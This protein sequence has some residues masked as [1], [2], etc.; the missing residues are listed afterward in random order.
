MLNLCELLLGVA[1][2]AT[3]LFD[4]F[5]S[6]VVPRWTPR[7]AFFRIPPLVVKSVWPVW[8]QLGQRLYPLKRREYFL[9]IFAPLALMLELL[10]WVLSLIFGYGLMLYAL[11]S[12]IQPVM[13]DFG[14]ALY[15]AGT[16]VF[17]LGFGDLVATG[18]ARVVVL[19]AAGSGLAVMS[20]MIALLFSLY[21]SLQ[22]RE[23]LVV[24]LDA[25]A[26]T[27]P[28]GAKLLE[29]Y[30]E[31]NML[32]ELPLT[33][34]AWEVWSAEIFE[35]HRAYP[36]LPFFRSTI[37]NNSW[38]SALG[39]MLDTCTLLITTVESDSYGAAK[40]MHRIGC[41]VVLDIYH[42][43]E[44]STVDEIGCEREQFEQVRMRLMR[45]GFQ[46]H[47]SEDAWRSFS[48]MRS[49]YGGAL[50]ALAKYFSTPNQKLGDSVVPHRYN[51]HLKGPARSSE[52]DKRI[53]G[54]DLRSPHSR[55]R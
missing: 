38:V 36:I 42:L 35:S 3:I 48:Q 37:E 4:V 34:T 25:R 43:F 39:V 19:F 50:N 7:R 49:T 31:F 33:F 29:T 30:A 44:L 40:L 28:S 54:G 18:V 45:A 32:E 21:S 20:L 55:D 12:E 47:N 24:L 52:H 26:G 6:I 10:L 46:L 9:S 23:V 41:R 17:T 2:I 27:P 5:L 22:R 53:A 51:Q 16:S 11:R 14:S 15:L 13:E 8:R 1:I